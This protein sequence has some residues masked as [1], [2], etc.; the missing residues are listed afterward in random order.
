MR[1]LGTVAV[2]GVAAAGTLALTSS[3]GQ[4][5]LHRLLP[6]LMQSADKVSEQVNRQARNVDLSPKAVT[7]NARAN[8][9]FLYQQVAGAWDA[10][11]GL[12]Y[13]TLAERQEGERRDPEHKFSAMWN[14]MHEGEVRGTR[15]MMGSWCDSESNV[16]RERAERAA[17]GASALRQNIPSSLYQDPGDAPPSPQ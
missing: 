2:V 13:G 6:D 1:L 12:A 10:M 14:V 11:C 16:K 7:A 17:R 9:S 15:P 5:A 4:I 8:G 3:P